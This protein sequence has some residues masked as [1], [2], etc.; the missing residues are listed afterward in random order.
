MSRGVSWLIGGSVILVA[1][2]GCG[3]SFLS[4]EQRAPWRKEAELACLNSG[5]VKEGAG[6]V[7]I[8]PID[9]PGMCGADFPLKVSALGESS[10]MGY[11][12]EPVRPPGAIPGVSRPVAEPRW[13]IAQQPYNAPSPRYATPQPQSGAPMSIE[14][15]S[16]VQQSAA[17]P[18]SYQQ[19]GAPPSNLR[20]PA[21][22]QRVQT[23]PAYQQQPVY[24]Q[25]QPQP[26]Y[27]PP[28]ATRQPQY[29]QAPVSVPEAE[30]ELPDYAQ[31]GA[32]PPAVRSQP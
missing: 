11:V 26:N 7:R 25:P 6:V 29:R 19:L 18:G 15:P 8:S 20:A 31:P 17:Q 12:D 5:T 4:Y 2:A 21:D 3:R 9:G 13:P 28:Q 30:E 27:A 32:P 16:A 1:L 24:G 10:A 14:A 22:W 23:Q